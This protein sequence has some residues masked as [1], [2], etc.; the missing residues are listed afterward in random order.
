MPVEI[1]FIYY[2]PYFNKL[3]VITV[4]L[5]TAETAQII[6]YFI[7]YSIS[8]RYIF[9][10]I[11]E[12]QILKAEKQIYS[13]GNLTILMFN[14]LPLSSSVISLAAGMIRYRFKTW[15]QG[16]KIDIYI[17]GSLL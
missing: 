10:I 12:K 16:G 15:S 2:L 8:T 3:E 1:A 5:F 9:K 13:Y 7:G 14:L 6:D 17:S 11:S 4:A